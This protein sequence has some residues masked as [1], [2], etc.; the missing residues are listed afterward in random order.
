MP[1]NS[2]VH[3]PGNRVVH[4]PGNWLVHHAGNRV[5]HD[6]GNSATSGTVSPMHQPTEQIPR[7]S[8]ARSLALL[9]PSTTIFYNHLEA[10]AK[11]LFLYNLPICQEFLLSRTP[12]ESGDTF[13][14]VPPGIF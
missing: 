2:L 9:P 13:K 8:F 11:A 14:N 5:V 12:K 1:G 6:G 10:R 4:D 7:R 3:T